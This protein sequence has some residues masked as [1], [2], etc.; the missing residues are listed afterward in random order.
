[1]VGACLGLESWIGRW[2]R[3]IAGTLRSV[4]TNLNERVFKGIELDRYLVDKETING[5]YL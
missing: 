2:R 5:P 3:S 4:I 1:M